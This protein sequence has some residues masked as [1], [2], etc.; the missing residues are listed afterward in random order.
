MRK[1]SETVLRKSKL[2]NN[3]DSIEF[4]LF[5]PSLNG[6]EI[7]ETSK[8]FNLMDKKMNAFYKSPIVEET[9]IVRKFNNIDK[10]FSPIESE[11]QLEE[12][13]LEEFSSRGGTTFVSSFAKMKIERFHF[14]KISLEQNKN[15]GDIGISRGCP[16]FIEE[17]DKVD[18]MFLEQNAQ[19]RLEDQRVLKS[20]TSTGESE[21]C[22]D[23][24]M[25]WDGECS[26]VL[27]LAAD[28]EKTVT[29]M[30]IKCIKQNGKG[31]LNFEL[32]FEQKNGNEGDHFG[33]LQFS[34]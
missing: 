25:E 3:P 22:N 26:S 1:I 6:R 29:M 19:R 12:F 31:K 8:L 33:N 32:F 18:R 7:K 15:I 34:N 17:I 16:H 2:Y 21:T 27:Q 28:A 20:V 30:M 13:C 23:D 14:F 5:R 9:N 24:L 10:I 4:G 11:P